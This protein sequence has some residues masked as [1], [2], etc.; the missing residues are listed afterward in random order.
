M[1]IDKFARLAL[2]TGLA[3]GG[4]ATGVGAGRSREGWTQ[5]DKVCKVQTAGTVCLEQR[6]S[7]RTGERQSRM[8]LTPKNGQWIRPEVHATFGWDVGTE[9]GACGLEGCAKVTEPMTGAWIRQR[10]E[11]RGLGYSTAQGTFNIYMG[12]TERQLIKKSGWK[13]EDPGRAAAQ[14]GR[15]AEEQQDVLHRPPAPAVRRPDVA[16]AP[17]AQDRA[18]QQ[19]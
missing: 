7:T 16:P 3:A 2:I 19:G 8:V 9:T 4:A 12:A 14:L 1:K 10:D 11:I 15:E 17:D 6:T 5:S 18:A 13:V